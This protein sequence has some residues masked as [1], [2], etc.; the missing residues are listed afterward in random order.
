M[1]PGLA[2]NPVLRSPFLK[3]DVAKKGKARMG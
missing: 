2:S 3:M 1:S